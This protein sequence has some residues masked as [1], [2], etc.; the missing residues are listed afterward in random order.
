MSILSDALHGKTTFLEGAHRTEQWLASLIGKNPQAAATATALQ[1]DVKQGLS[2][3]VSAG[4]TAL[5]DHYAELVTGGEAL[6]EAA[7]AKA[8]G[9]VSIPFNPLISAGVDDIAKMLK[10]AADTWSLETKAKLA[11][12]A[13]AAAKAA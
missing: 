7:L 4:S 5:S 3:A 9:G 8:T 10:A 1:G 2:D 12:P 6:L 13:T 11:Q